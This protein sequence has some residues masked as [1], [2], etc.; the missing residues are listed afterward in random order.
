M[1]ASDDED[2]LLFLSSV[3]NDHRKSDP[4]KS[5]T[6]RK[7]DESES[8]ERY[9]ARIR[10]DAKLGHSVERL[11]RRVEL[12]DAKKDELEGT[13]KE[14]KYVNGYLFYLFVMKYYKKNPYI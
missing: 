4:R 13:V 11:K 9:F 8:D 6:N 14:L 12:M 3:L 10:D 1:G 2:D 7:F 5:D